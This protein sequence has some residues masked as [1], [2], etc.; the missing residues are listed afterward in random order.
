[1]KNKR[2]I[3]IFS[4]CYGQA[5]PDE[6]LSETTNYMKQIGYTKTETEEILL[7]TI[8]LMGLRFITQLIKRK[9]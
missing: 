4:H 9:Y 2:N 8:V 3:N 6:I 7:K 5:V 1:M